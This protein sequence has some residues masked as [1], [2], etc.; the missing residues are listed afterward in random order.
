MQINS[1]ALQRVRSGQF[2]PDAIATIFENMANLVGETGAAATEFTLGYQ[3]PDDLVTE[4]DMV[5]VIVLALRP[6][7]K[8]PE[9]PA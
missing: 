8:P 6:A 3:H 4:G 7:Q 5:P 2:R 1:S 9:K